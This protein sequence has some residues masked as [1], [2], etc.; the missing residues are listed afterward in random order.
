MAKT[1]ETSF[2]GENRREL[3]LT[4]YHILMTKGG[5]KR[6]KLAVEMPISNKPAV[7]MPNWIGNPYLEMEKEDSRTARS[8]IEVMLEGMT[9]T[10]FSTDKIKRKTLSA[11]GVMLTGFHLVRV[12]DGE[13]KEAVLRFVV[14][15]PANIQLRDW[16]WEHMRMKFFAEF[17]YSQTE[18]DFEA[19]A[20]TDDGEEE[21]ESEFMGAQHDEAFRSPGTRANA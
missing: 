1:K 21:A 12:G 17:E 14:Y 20:E 11:T 3:S 9:I 2:F 18:M 5:E 10:V 19:E 15:V 16:A 13:K 6:I 8:N 4:D 7:A